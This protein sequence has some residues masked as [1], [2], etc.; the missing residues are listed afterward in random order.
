[1]GMIDQRAA[2]V[3]RAHLKPR[4]NG[5]NEDMKERLRRIKHVWV[6][7][8]TGEQFDIGK[9]AADALDARDAEI[10]RLRGK[11]KRLENA[12]GNLPYY[13]GDSLPETVQVDY[14]EVDKLHSIAADLKT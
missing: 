11:L 3:V 13:E 2:A 10:A 5:M 12:I 4:E 7:Q 14:D 6:E 9:K 8:R 1:M